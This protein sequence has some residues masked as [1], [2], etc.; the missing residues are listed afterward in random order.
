MNGGPPR[1]QTLP[2][3]P[4]ARSGGGA[5][6]APPQQVTTIALRFPDGRTGT[7]RFALETTSLADIFN[8][9]DAEFE[10]ERE[11]ITLV[12]LNGQHSFEWSDDGGE[13]DEDHG[14]PRLQEAGLG[15]MVGF[16]VLPKKEKTKDVTKD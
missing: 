11:T 13:H 3:E 9:V 16:R 15:K 12:T 4:P 5:G 7:R 1:A 2:E 8:W 10:M 6:G 14:L